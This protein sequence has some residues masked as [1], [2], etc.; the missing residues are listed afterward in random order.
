MTTKLYDV[1]SKEVNLIIE[2]IGKI[3]IKDQL[4][5]DSNETQESLDNSYTYLAA[6]TKTLEKLEGETDEEY[7][8]RTN[9]IVTEYENVDIIHGAGNIVELNPYY[10]DLKRK[11]NIKPAIARLASDFALLYEPTYEPDTLLSYFNTIYA[12]SSKY[13]YH[14]IYSKALEES[15][16]HNNVSDGYRNFCRLTICL[17][18]MV[19]LLNQRLRDPFDIK[20]MD[21]YMVD[22]FLYSFGF[23]EFKHF[24]TDYKQ[25]L[26][27]NIN[28]LIRHKGTDQVFID[29][30]E[31]FDFRNIDI[32]KFY[33]VR[34]ESEKG[35]KLNN[36]DDNITNIKDHLRFISQSVKIPSLTDAIIS[37]NYREESYEDIID[38]DEYWQ[39]E[40]SHVEQYNFDYI[41]S[42]YFSVEASFDVYREVINTVYILNLIKQL[43]DLD[44]RFEEHLLRVFIKDI[45]N[46]YIHVTHIINA[47]QI[48][49]LDLF[50]IEDYIPYSDNKIKKIYQFNNRDLYNSNMKLYGADNNSD[51]ATNPNTRYILKDIPQEL[52]DL[53]DDFGRLNLIDTYNLNNSTRNNILDSIKSELNYFRYKDKVNSYNYKFIADYNLDEYVPY[54]RYSDYL[55]DKNVD[56]YKYVI[57]SIENGKTN[58]AI[59]FL[60]DLL[61]EYVR[62]TSNL[63]INSAEL[64]ILMNY[65]KTLVLTF[66]SYTI[67]LE[68]LR[69]IFTFDEDHF[70]RLIDD[71]WFTSKFDPEELLDL[72]DITYDEAFIRLFLYHKLSDS[73]EFVGLI[74]IDE[75][76]LLKELLMFYG[77]S[78]M[79]TPIMYHIKSEFVKHN[80]LFDG[81][82]LHD[83]ILH[84]YIE[85][86][87]TLEFNEE[88]LTTKVNFSTPREYIDILNYND[89]F[90]NIKIYK[91]IENIN[92]HD[93]FIINVIV[94][95]VLTVADLNNITIIPDEIVIVSWDDDCGLSV[96]INWTLQ[97][98]GELKATGLE[99]HYGLN[100]DNITNII[101]LPV[102]TITYTFTDVDPR[103][104]HEIYIIPIIDTG[105]EI[106]RKA[107]PNTY[108]WKIVDES[109]LPIDYILTS[110][111]Y[112]F[113]IEENI[114]NNSLELTGGIFKGI[115]NLPYEDISN[116][117]FNIIGGELR[118]ILTTYSENENIISN[119]SFNITGGELRTIL[120][121][122]SEN[123]NIISNGNFNITGGNLNKIL[124][125]SSID[126]SINST[127]FNITGGELKKL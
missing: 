43:R 41:Q 106:I 63:I 89:S 78:I 113:S 94:D 73:T 19:Y 103:I 93:N 37:G 79:Y 71:T 7:L 15:A 14:V 101:S 95:N 90:N 62:G 26:I 68:E 54:F 118:T 61:V 111:M 55:K 4:L 77:L 91:E 123:E 109:L 102:S 24:P 121:T 99:I 104:K 75:D 114:S 86:S 10:I 57:E 42:K 72:Q 12:T 11:Y 47:L 127:S 45:S 107:L 21:E 48:L 9:N 22:N 122:Y 20:L 125:E 115:V 34:K 16:I 31:I 13:F 2:H 29:I 92:V 18:T 105:T 32:V 39:L 88:I 33:F 40:K 17:M 25:K 58:S 98:D 23:T 87:N 8:L 30:L 70:F 74:E 81:L 38:G 27:S 110:S 76:I 52:L 66:K 3:V 117:T 65:I 6:Y 69:L 124:I 120:T 46:N 1:T 80:E 97:V 108:H 44:P 36:N 64:D 49:V 56:L 53:N 59:V 5:A 100:R 60:S 85:E 67:D 116:S 82:P 119:G 96:K 126:D 112:P 28:R 50:K 51:R 84:E 35:Y 83:R